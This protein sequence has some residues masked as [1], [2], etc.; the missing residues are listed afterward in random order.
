MDVHPMVDFCILHIYRTHHQLSSITNGAQ[1]EKYETWLFYNQSKYLGSKEKVD[2]DEDIHDNKKTHTKNVSTFTN[3]CFQVLQTSLDL[4][5][6]V[7]THVPIKLV[8]G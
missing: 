6:F 7:Y 1:V 8:I 2:S 4:I 3:A 5:I